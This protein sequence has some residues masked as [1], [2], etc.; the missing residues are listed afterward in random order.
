MLPVQEALSSLESPNNTVSLAEKA[1]NHMD[2]E[3]KPTKSCK[4]GDICQPQ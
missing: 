2:R 1:I 3:G 4:E